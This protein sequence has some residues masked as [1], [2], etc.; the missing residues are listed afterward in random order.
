MKR[1]TKYFARG[2]FTAAVLAL[3]LP[4]SANNNVHTS[5]MWH[6]HQPIY[7]PDRAPA[8][9]FGDHYQTAWDTMQLQDGGFTHPTGDPSMRTTFGDDNRVH[10]YQDYP[11]GVLTAIGGFAPNSGGQ[12]SFSGALMENIS[13]L[14]AASQYYGFLGHPWNWYSQQAHSW[15]TQTSG[16]TRLDL[17]NFTYHHCIAPFVSDET[18]EME[19][20]IHQREQQIIWGA[21]TTNLISR[22]FFPAETCFSERIIPT[23]AK[24][25]ITWSVVANNH[26]TRSCPD[27][28][29][30]T[31]QSGE[32]CDLP[33][34]A[35]QIN[36][37]QG[38][39]NYITRG[40]TSLGCS[41]TAVAPFAFQMHYARYVNPS[42]GVASTLIVVPADQ[43][44]GWADSFGTWAPNLIAPIASRN[45]T[46]KPTFLMFAH[47]GDNAWAQG[48]DYW[49]TDGGSMWAKTFASDAV[50]AGYEPSTVEQFLSEFPPSANDVVH[51]EDGGWVYDQGGNDFG[52]PLMVGWHYPPSYTTNVSPFKVVDPSRG[53]SDKADAWR[54]IVA[55]EN[56]I[57]TA[58]Q[59]TNSISGFL[60]TNRIDQIRDPG[61]GLQPANPVE[62]G[63]H[64]YLG[65]LDS[66]FV[67][68][69]CH[70][71][72]CWRQAIAQSNAVRNVDSIVTNNL[73]LDATPPTVFVPQRSPWNPGTTNFGVEY[74]S[75]IYVPSNT[76]FWVWTYAYDVSGIANA[77]L[78]Y[79]SNGGTPPTNDQFK[80]YA[81]GPTTGPWISLPMAQRVLGSQN[82]VLPPKYIADYYYAKVTGLSDTYVDYYVEA[83]DGRGNVI[84]SPIQH[85]YVSPNPGGPPTVPPTPTGVSATA[86]AT[87]RIDVSWASSSGATLYYVKRDGNQIATIA[88]TSISDIGLAPATQY[89]YSIIASNNLGAS[90][91]SA[92]VCATTPTPSPPNLSPPF[93]M[94]GTID[95]TNYLQSAPGMTLYAA[96][97]GD[98][99]Y[100][101]TYS[102]G[103]YPGDNNKND[104]FILVTD[105]LS[106]TL[107]PAFPTWSKAG[108]NA[109]ATTKPFLGG[110]SINNYVGWQNTTASNACI[111]AATNTGTMEGVINLTQ[112][113]GSVP[114]NIFVFAA[115]YNTTN[116]AALFLQAPAGNGNGNIE[117]NEFLMLSI[118]AITDNDGNGIYDR[119]EPSKGFVIQKI[120]PAVAGGF[121][122]TWAAVPGK[123]YEVMYCD[124]LGGGW[125]FLIQKTAQ[126]G[127][128]TLSH[129][130]NTALT[131]RFYKVKCVNP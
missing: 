116:G 41:P 91:A 123:T 24:L 120:Q 74:N 78:R 14:S 88:G 36:P 130:D 1:G 63:W 9:H 17:V 46:N 77:T 121:T 50:N 51:V 43:L 98:V 85:V 108:S 4:A 102:P 33:N 54:V 62:L 35:D 104:H 131:H 55:T 103:I 111:K 5:W 79:R 89:C 84:K 67:Y 99:L 47:D 81:D 60:Y 115:A 23:L 61:T 106:P 37:A 87:N 21:G 82:T 10:D 75:N 59:I 32:A 110:E 31:G 15:T 22:G 112:A 3:S 107:Q 71:D 49:G 97:R 18:L 119:L 28:P 8:N 48:H 118:P 66:G 2:L 56:R 6:M 113:F 125:Q 92:P 30:L 93:V 7:W 38:A 68:F 16:K 114:S 34:K 39:G 42:D 11:Y 40:Y 25:G 44:L 65:G 122:I 57:K 86:M 27:F 12:M 64:Y 58:Q 80:V 94:D 20:R 52:S 100:V 53:V 72:E 83:T 13:S 126:T 26:L 109:V 117:S 124:S 70:D 76:D 45:D 73:T 96:V 95:S 105:Q 101:A 90:L 127:E 29:V 128:I 129:T 69:G 19:I